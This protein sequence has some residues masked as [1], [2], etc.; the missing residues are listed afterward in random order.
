[1]CDRSDVAIAN[2]KEFVRNKIL[3]R[4]FLIHQFCLF[5]HNSN[6]NV[7]VVAIMNDH[8]GYVIDNS[9]V[10]SISFGC[11]V[12]LLSHINSFVEL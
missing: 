5:N 2:T 11:S 7:M 10:I 3:I 6:G 12:A 1:M 9:T 8:D 4:N